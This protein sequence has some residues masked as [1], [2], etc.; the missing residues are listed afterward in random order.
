[1]KQGYALAYSEH[2]ALHDRV[3]RPRQPESFSTMV[4]LAQGRLSLG[5]EEPAIEG[6]ALCFWPAGARPT[7]CLSAGSSAQVLELSDTITL[8]AVGARAES[9]HLRML[10]EKPFRAPLMPR[11]NETQVGILISWFIEELTE[12]ERQSPMSLSALLR[13]LFIAA[14][15]SYQPE[16][17]ETGVELTTILRRF[18]HLVE[19]HYRDHWQVARYAEELGVDYDRLQRMC[20]RETGRSPGELV[21]ERLTAEA[22]ALLENTGSPLKQI[23]SDLGFPD[24]TRFSHFFK[25]RTD[26]APGAYRAVVSRPD[27]EDLLELRRG[28]SDWP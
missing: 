19:L 11:Q 9:V 10:I 25:R 15:R 5:E 18:R 26:M 13:L 23:A 20:K 14:L 24:A 22:K 7:V 3:L 1:M 12:P 8:D 28:F 27:G 17:V 4:F 21:H 16:P 2:E 6:P